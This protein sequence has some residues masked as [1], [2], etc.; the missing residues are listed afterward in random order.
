MSP[1]FSYRLSRH[2]A[3]DPQAPALQC[4]DITV[5]YPHSQRTA[6]TQISLKVDSGSRIALIGANGSGKSTLLK[7]IAGVMPVET[8]WI[9]VHGASGAG[10]CHRI[11]YLAQRGELDWRFPM[12][13][14]RLVLTGRYVHLGWLARPGNADRE[15]VDH[16]MQQLRIDHLAEQAIAE[17]SGGQQQRA[18]LARAMAQDAQML[19]LDEPMN[20]VDAQTRQIIRDRLR[21]LAEQGKT[22]VVATHDLHDI[23]FEFDR[24]VKL[25]EGRQIENQSRADE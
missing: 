7:V 9:R 17:L 8:G 4:H 11:A 25:A 1:R 24:V 21:A 5:R 12:T 18:L 23:E 3:P 19:L 13:V 15:I 10:C 6:L 22:I 20:A 2:G 14:R 16:V